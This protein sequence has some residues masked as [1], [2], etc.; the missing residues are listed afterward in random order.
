[1]IYTLVKS[2]MDI[3]VGL[4]WKYFQMV[5]TTMDILT[6][7]YLK[8]RGS[9]SGIGNNILLVTSERGRNT[10]AVSMVPQA[11]LVTSKIIGGMEREFVGILMDKS[12]TGTGSKGKD[13]GMGS[14][15]IITIIDI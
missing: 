13:M 3:D 10:M 5:N 8:A 11:I 7:T 12:I 1:M 4:A 2:R 14:I 15:K 9:I 6:M